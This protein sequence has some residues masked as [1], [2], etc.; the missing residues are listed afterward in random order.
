MEPAEER[1]RRIKKLR[2]RVEVHWARL[3]ARRCE[4]KFA[5]ENLERHEQHLADVESGGM[6]HIPEVRE[7]AGNIDAF[8][9]EVRD[10]LAGHSIRLPD[11]EDVS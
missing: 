5:R 2:A 4:L 1:L 7:A 3:E 11:L 8:M 6:G 10:L 9:I